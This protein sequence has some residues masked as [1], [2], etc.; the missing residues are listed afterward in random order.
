[1]V[2]IGKYMRETAPARLPGFFRERAN[3]REA[4]CQGLLNQ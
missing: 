2:T 4:K 3:G 1:L